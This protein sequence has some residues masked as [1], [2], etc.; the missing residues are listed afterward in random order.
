MADTPETK[1]KVAKILVV[2]DSP[3]QLEELRFLLEE[4]GFSVVATTN[5]KEALAAAKANAIDLVISDI[6]MPE[7]DGY[8]LCKALR[9]DET[10]RHLPV[11]LLTSLADPRDVI[12]GLESGANNFICKPYNDRALLARVHNVLANQEI[13]K[14]SLSEMGISILFSGQRFFITA[15]R[16]QILDLL[17]STYENAVTR[18]TE[19]IRARDELRILNEQ[20]EVQVAKRTAMLMKR[21]KELKCLFAISNL[22][23]EPQG[24][25]NELL[26][27][28]AD[29]IPPGWQYPEITRARIV[30]E[31]REF[32]SANFRDSAWKQSA[33]IVIS[34]R[35]VGTVEVCYLEERPALEEGPFSKE[36]R[37]LTTDI[38][39]RLGGRIERQWAEEA[40]AASEV[41]YRRLFESAKDGILILDAET[42]MI[43]DVNPFLIELLGSPR[44]HFLRQHIWDLGFFKDIVSNKAMFEEL[45]R[46]DYIRYE[47]LPLE[48]AE[49]RP[50][51]VEFVSNVYQAGGKKVIQCNVRDITKR[52]RAEK[53]L[54]RLNRALR[55]I[56]ECNQVLVHVTDE[57]ALLRGVCEILINVGGYRMAWVGYA[58]H[59]ERRTVRPAAVSGYEEGYLAC[60]D[61][62][63]S[64][65]ESGHGPVSTAIRTG[66]LQTVHSITAD[67]AF[68]I[69]R[70]EAM[71][72]GY[73]SVIALP[74]RSAGSTLGALALYAGESRV[75]DDEE[76][77]LLTQLADDLV[78]GIQTLRTRAERDLMIEELKRI[79]WML[80]KKP[81]S[82]VE[83]QA[84]ALEQGYGDLTELNRD[85]LI[86]KSVGREMLG[87]IT[88]EYLDLLGTSTAAYEANGDYAFGI[89]ASGWCRMLDQASRNLCDTPD[90]AAAL[91]SGKWLCHE[92]CWT[93]C[94]KEAIAKR[95]PVDIECAGGIRLFSVPI[96][97]HDEV[98]GAINFGYGDPPKDPAKL[99][100]LAD[101]YRL[102]YKE[103]RREAPAYD[104]RPPYIIEMAKGRLRSSARLIGS[105]VEVKQAEVA[106]QKM[107]AQFHQ[108]Q[109]MEAVGRL[110]G[111]VAHDFNNLLTVINGY[112]QLLLERL[113]AESLCRKPIEEIH[114]A[115]ERAT[116][117]TRQLLAFSRKQILA[118]QVTDLNAIVPDIE[119]M[120]RRLI[121]EDIELL[122]VLRPNLGKVKVDTGQI[123]QVLTNLVV[124]ARDAM[125]QG[126]R[127]TIETADVE[128]DATYVQTRDGVT[129]GRYVMLAVSDTGHGM[130]AETQSHIFEPF[131]TTKEVGKGTGLGL[132]TVYGIVKQSGGYVWVYSEPGEGTVVK[133]YL[134]RVEEAQAA[135][136]GRQPSA[137]ALGG[138][139]TILMAEDQDAVRVL[140]CEVLKS[141][142]YKVL[143]ASQGEEALRMAREHEGPIHLLV[144]DVVM[145]GMGGRDLARNLVALRPEMK[146]LYMSGYTG[147]AIVNHGVIEEGLAFIQKPFAPAALARKVREVLGAA[148]L[149]EAWAMG[150]PLG[151]A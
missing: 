67:P 119:K 88:S 44:E 41:R 61:I 106:R 145:P 142:G 77:K 47:S 71:K 27:A 131:F 140:V 146:V 16:L 29:L 66:Q 70:E 80:S 72:R 150:Q 23:A 96:F 134:P 149:E 34:G 6:V 21:I 87:G 151:P 117:L 110:A 130:D 114:K 122:T 82:I 57:S 81:A 65:A 98:I 109:K 24:S 14:A 118:P 69:W 104:S 83:G 53:Q 59:D 105:M 46:K 68:P 100:E 1:Q 129:A 11:I 9:A 108:A 95:A 12:R 94:S 2:E 103:L 76:I 36:E 101:A 99:R 133:I 147:D 120:L 28:A 64:D 49:G 85:G 60:V 91:N 111:G 58:E 84:E 38:A 92:S 20:L 107:E 30:L 74:L 135:V 90:N 62:T 113:D 25:I 32:A 132:A 144:T 40:L 10:L 115:G 50:T 112:C 15:D 102:D 89:F 56:S 86:L 4:S 143:E 26:K 54:R 75:F 121:G 7:M 141:K 18:N 5:G 148:P 3:T 116:S 139:E 48:T 51:D 33:D 8:A 31:G 73:A 137:P 17:L 45:Q 43:V 78:Y 39:R 63:W 127:I 136:E 19:L 123:E 126:G 79:E 13:R 97:A 138:N 35:T 52:K 55:T 93:C 124:N 128:L 37:D 125:P 42:G 22:V